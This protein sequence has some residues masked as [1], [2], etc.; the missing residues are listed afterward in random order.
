MVGN[1]LKNLRE[2]AG[3]TQ[4][5]LAKLL[6]ISRTSVTAWENSTN[7]PNATYLIELS[8]LY[9][10]SVDYI[11]GLDRVESLCLDNLNDEEKNVLLHLWR[12]IRANRQK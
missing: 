12:Y 10:R 6:G 9:G 7:S 8:K 3:Y 2:Q 4:L 5:E 11:L 1:T